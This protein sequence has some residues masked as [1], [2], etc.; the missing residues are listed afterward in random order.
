MQATPVKAAGRR[1]SR[2]GLD[3]LFI[4]EAGFAQMD[5]HVDESRDHRATPSVDHPLG[6]RGRNFSG[7]V[8]RGDFS[9][10]D[11]KIAEGVVIERGVD[12]AAA[13]E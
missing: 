3:R 13:L 12:D 1:R 4:F 5:V 7:P 10:L 2:A 11:Q 8:D 6:A 9:V